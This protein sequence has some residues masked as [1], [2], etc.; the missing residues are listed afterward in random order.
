ML[1]SAFSLDVSGF[2]F[3]AKDCFTEFWPYITSKVWTSAMLTL[4][5]DRST[6]VLISYFY[7]KSYSVDV[8][9][10]KFFKKHCDKASNILCA[11]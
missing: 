1:I 7:F 9:M 11:Y 10:Y 8:Y 3:R 5:L 4:W 2:A 6:L